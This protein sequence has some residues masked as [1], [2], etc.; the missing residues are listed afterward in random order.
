MCCC[1]SLHH[2]LSTQA[3]CSPTSHHCCLISALLPTT[4]PNTHSP[5]YWRP[6][7]SLYADTC[8]NL[9]T[10]PSL[11]VMVPST[12]LPGC[13]TPAACTPVF[14][15]AFTDHSLLEFSQSVSQWWR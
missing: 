7:C 12:S 6:C 5:L 11:L 2:R 4:I 9:L 8:P 1:Y 15:D 10:A 13:G 3:A 14:P